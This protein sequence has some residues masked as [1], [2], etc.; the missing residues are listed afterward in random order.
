MPEKWYTPRHLFNFSWRASRRE[1]WLI[2]VLSFIAV[3]LPIVAMVP[4]VEP[5]A[6]PEEPS[7]GMGLLGIVWLGLFLLSYIVTIAVFVRRLHDQEKSGWW[8]F[9]IF[10]PLVGWIFSLVFIFTP[11]DEEENLYGPNPRYGGRA[12]SADEL[13]SVFD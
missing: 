5:G 8:Y 6:S 2:T 11:G 13:E 7:R 1:F 10:I 9:A 4:W 12:E 3:Y